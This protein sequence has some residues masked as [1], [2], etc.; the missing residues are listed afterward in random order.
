MLFGSFTTKVIGHDVDRIVST[1]PVLVLTAQRHEDV[2]LDA[3]VI[4]VL[5]KPPDIATLVA[6]IDAVCELGATHK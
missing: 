3:N 4:G 6:L 2:P 1:I 5:V